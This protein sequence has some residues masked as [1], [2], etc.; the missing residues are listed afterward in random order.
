MIGLILESIG[1]DGVEAEPQG[2]GLLADSGGIAGDIP[3]DMEGDGA[4]GMGQGMEQAYVVEFLFQAARLASDGKAAEAGSAGAQ[5]PTGDSY[6][7]IF[8]FS[9]DPRYMYAALLQLGG[10]R[11][12]FV[13]VP[14]VK[15][16]V[17]CVY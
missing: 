5:C 15:G 8:D 2:G 7:K 17:V 12:V 11:R 10:E 9:Y 3:R 16:F 13:C 6:L 4:C 14:L 1:V